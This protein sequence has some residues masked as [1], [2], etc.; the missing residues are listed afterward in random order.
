MEPEVF[1]SVL[2]CRRVE[3]IEFSRA[4]VY[5]DQIGRLQRLPRLKCI[6]V[7]DVAF[8]QK[9]L[10]AIGQLPGL[11]EIS[12][13]TPSFGEF[14]DEDLAHFRNLESLQL[15][16]LLDTYVTGEGFVYLS[17]LPNLRDALIVGNVFNDAGIASLGRCPHIEVLELQGVDVTD[18]GLSGLTTLTNLKGF[19]CSSTPFSDAAIKHLA[20]IDSLESL[21]LHGT[22]LTGRTLGELRSLKKLKMLHLGYLTLIEDDAIPELSTLQQIES[23]YLCG[24]GF[25]DEGRQ[26]L[27]MAMPNTFVGFSGVPYQRS[28]SESP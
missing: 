21:E 5:A 24:A 9:S 1:D 6:S 17:K 13:S 27:K 23:L 15:L 16:H 25:S 26:R 18:D 20:K 28:T 19:Q 11:F 12:I 7:H 4:D 8:D 14:S 2:K 10:A 22:R 3:F